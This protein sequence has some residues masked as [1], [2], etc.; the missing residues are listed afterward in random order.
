MSCNNKA[1]ESKSGI[2]VVKVAYTIKGIVTEDEEAFD[3]SYYSVVKVKMTAMGLADEALYLMAYGDVSYSGDNS[4]AMM[5]GNSQAYMNTPWRALSTTQLMT[6]GNQWNPASLHLFEPVNPTVEVHF[7]N[8]PGDTS[9]FILD[10]MEVR[11]PSNVTIGNLLRLEET[12]QTVTFFNPMLSYIN[13]QVTLGEG[14]GRQPLRGYLRGPYTEEQMQAGEITTLDLGLTDD[15][16]VFGTDDLVMEEDASFQ[17]TLHPSPVNGVIDSLAF[18]GV[19]AVKFAGAA[20][21]NV[22]FEASSSAGLER[23]CFMLKEVSVSTLNQIVE[24]S[25]YDEDWSAVA[26]NLMLKES[27][28]VSLVSGQTEFAVGSDDQQCNRKDVEGIAGKR[29]EFSVRVVEK[30]GNDLLGVWKMVHGKFTSVLFLD[31][32]MEVPEVRSD[33]VPLRLTTSTDE[34]AGGDIWTDNVNIVLEITAADSVDLGGITVEFGLNVNFAGEK[35]MRFDMAGPGRTESSNDNAEWYVADLVGTSED[36]WKD[37]FGLDWMRVGGGVGH[38]EVRS[39]QDWEQSIMRFELAVSVGEWEEEVTID[40]TVEAG[41]E[42]VS[43]RR[44]GGG[45]E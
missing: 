19:L 29:V 39:D 1:F 27:N 42:E 40:V 25:T 5:D 43:D 3:I 18:V 41:G 15:W 34:D 17:V 28:G 22:I 33:G 31:C 6:T 20:K 14:E 45:G 23:F 11:T 38:A 26:E 4:F 13:S 12:V 30:V 10:Q 36:E 2:N 21:S 16:W 7:S 35:V 32:V 24:K 44:K 9:S 37:C 8:A